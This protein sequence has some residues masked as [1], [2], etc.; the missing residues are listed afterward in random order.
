MGLTKIQALNAYAIPV[1]SYTG[2]IIDWTTNELK[3][4]DRK[5]RKLLTIHK[6]LHP[7]AGVDRLYVSR[8]MGGRGLKKIKHVIEREVIGLGTTSGI[9][10]KMIH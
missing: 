6:A 3:E 8:K 9:T 2:G 4:L 1:V 10:A 5:T 7:K